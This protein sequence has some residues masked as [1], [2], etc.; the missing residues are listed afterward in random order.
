MRKH[1]V[2]V[3]AALVGCGG[4]GDDGGDVPGADGADGD[5]EMVEVTTYTGD[6]QAPL[7]FAAAQ[8][9]DGEWR[10]VESDDGVYSFAAESGRYG[11][12]YACEEG[13]LRFFYSTVAERTRLSRGCDGPAATGVSVR[14]TVDG[15]AEGQ[16]VL[17]GIG[18]QL[19]GVDDQSPSVDITDVPVGVHDVVVT[20]VDES[21]RF[22]IERG[23]TIGDADPVQLA[24]DAADFVPAASY[25]ISANVE[26]PYRLHLQTG[27]G[28]RGLL[29]TD[30]LANGFRA[31]PSAHLEPA[32]MHRLHFGSAVTTPRPGRSVYHFFHEPRD[33]TVTAPPSFILSEA[34]VV[35]TEPHVRAQASFDVRTDSVAYL[36]RF[37]PA[38]PA[39]FTEVYLSSAWIGGGTTY[40]WQ[41]PDFSDLQGWNPSWAL[42]DDVEVTVMGTE[43]IGDI[44]PL[45]A[46]DPVPVSSSRWSA[47]WDGKQLSVADATAT[48]VP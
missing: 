7:V 25:S 34:S 45:M 24:F 26:S 10:V 37:A 18:Q 35:A 38:A 3:V 29:S 40:T 21:G 47:D 16:Q 32:D 15:L 20:T 14:V 6:I 36:L 8:D 42:L 33:L 5:D 30:T 48:F 39:Y 44:D 2:L 12:A 31:V 9:G 46:L 22:L 28:S 23:V 13:W 41:Q 19:S 1:A 11:F 4:G 27:A 17:I 43:I